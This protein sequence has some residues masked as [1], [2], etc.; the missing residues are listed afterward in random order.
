[1][2]SHNTRNPGTPL[3]LDWVYDARVNRSAVERRTATLPGRR[4]IKKEWQAAWLLR[5]VTCIDLT[6]LAGDDTPGRVRRLCAKAKQPLRPDMLERPGC[7][8]S[9]YHGGRRMC[10]SQP[11]ARRRRSPA[12]HRY[13]CRFRG[14]R[15]PRRANASA[16]AHGRN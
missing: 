10:L 9:R 4:S 14:D 7:C 11:R 6:T 2:A 8:R 15:F 16:A 12:G 3:D 1:M 5:A 13:P